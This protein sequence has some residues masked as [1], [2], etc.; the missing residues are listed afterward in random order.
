[1]DLVARAAADRVMRVALEKLSPREREIL[2]REPPARTQRG[3]RR[4]RLNAQ[5][6]L[7]GTLI[8]LLEIQPRR[9][10]AAQN[11]P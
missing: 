2:K 7:L 9:V 3:Q 6:P 1:M 11:I 4:E 10:D 8:G 5:Q